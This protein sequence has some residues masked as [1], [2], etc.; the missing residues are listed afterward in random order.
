ML[1]YWNIGL[2]IYHPGTTSVALHYSIVPIFNYLP[3]S[4]SPCLPIYL[5]SL[6]TR[7][8]TS[9]QISP[10]MAHPVHCPSASQTT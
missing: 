5:H 2:I 3:P 4:L 9:G 6:H 8:A 1:E 7:M 10:Q